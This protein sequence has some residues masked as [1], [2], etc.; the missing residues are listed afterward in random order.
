MPTLYETLG[1][2][3]SA[4]PEQIKRSYKRLVKRLHPDL[5]P[6]ESEAQVDA[7]EQL[8]EVNA[9]YAV[10]SH[11]GRKASYDSKLNQR[12]AAYAH[13]DPEYCDRC[14]KPTLYW[15]VGLKAG[16]CHEC[17]R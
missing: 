6:A 14:G 8:R 3:E 10:L 1:I 7:E 4:K 12:R 11:P 13:P 17:R 9:A 5:F 16:R 2:S 15:Q